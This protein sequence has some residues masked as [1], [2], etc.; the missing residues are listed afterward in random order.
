[1]NI[2]LIGII[3]LL[4]IAVL[5]CENRRAIS[6]RITGSAFILQAALAVVV[7]YVPLGK[8]ILQGL[9]GGVQKIIDYTN[10][11]IL[12]LFG[13][14]LGGGLG[15]IFAFRVLPIII[16]VSSLMAVLYHLHIMQWVV[17]IVGGALR[18]IVG[19]SRVESICAAANIFFGP[20]EAP[21]AIRPY[22]GKLTRPQLFSVMAV[23]LSSISGA[24]LV[25]YAS[26][27]IGL[28]YLIAAA[29]MAAPGGLLMAKLLVPDD[30]DLFDDDD[31][32]DVVG[33]DGENRPVNVI[34]AAADGATVGVKLAAIIGGMLLAF[35]ALISMVNGILSSLGEWVGLTGLTLETI[36]GTV[37][38]PLMFLLGI[39]WEEAAIAGNLV[40]QKLVLN[41]F[42]AFVQMVEIQDQLSQHTRAV[43]T[44]ALCG[45]ANLNALAIL[46]G[47]LGSMIPE[48][49]HE[50]AEL[51]LKAVLA[52]TLS[53][54]MSAAIVS[55]LL[56]I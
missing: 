12:F 34:E 41:E 36:L 55:V 49:K 51:G 25:G 20:T 39:P 26:L 56:S 3:V 5:F 35:V 42:I 13:E 8:T 1:M 11:G 46:L 24:I 9:S 15:F 45:F 37:F 18:R 22:L 33:F 4:S 48:R 32:L 23:G 54:L 43:V 44:F 19:T 16:F 6:L 2:A 29:F 17:K 27:G 47:G 52:G 31:A 28:D 14:H 10:D 38:S 21:L 30:G 7:L 50:I 53:N 40:G